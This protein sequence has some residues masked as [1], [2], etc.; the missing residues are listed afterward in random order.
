MRGAAS[1]LVIAAI[2]L[3][4]PAVSGAELL[5]GYTMTSWTL[6]DGM[7]IGPVSAMVQDADGYLWLGTTS[8]VMRFDGARFTSWDALYPTR[9]PRRDVLALA[10]SRDGTFWIGFDRSADGVSVAAWKNGT[11]TFPAAGA[12]P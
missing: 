12:A 6:A 3:A 1:F 9:L 4:Q 8:G 2:G 5:T 7:P 10:L 11:L